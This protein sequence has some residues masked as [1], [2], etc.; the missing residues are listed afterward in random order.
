MNTL[1]APTERLLD[2]LAHTEE[3][4]GVFYTDEKPVNGYGPKEGELLTREREAAGEIDWEK[5]FGNFSCV[6]GNLWKARKKKTAAWLSHQA[7]GCMGGGYYSGMYRPYLETNV[8]YVSHGIPGTHMEGEHYITPEGMRRFMDEVD[9]PA[10]P[11]AY[12]VMK[13]L[14]HFSDAEP[15]LVV[16]FFARPEV[17][18][19]LH[20]LT[21]YASGDP[22]AVVSPFGAC[23]TQIIRWPQVYAAR[24][25]EKAVLGGFD[26]SARKFLK[27][28]E[29]TFAVP[30]SLYEKMLGVMEKSALT[31]HTWRNDRTKVLRSRRAW[32]EETE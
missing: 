7:C 2:L 10:P 8:A 16:I 26:P 9:P 4:Y 20:V 11:A 6:I 27:T 32:G 22:H 24:G 30:R 21:T 28:D 5:A 18:V 13:P 12:C 31:R 29:M 1:T 19:G 23:C 17:L 14:S 3:P 25:E 15:P